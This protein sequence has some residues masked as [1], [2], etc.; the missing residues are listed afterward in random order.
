[1]NIP[2]KLVKIDAV[3]QKLMEWAFIGGLCIMWGMALHG[4]IL[5]EDKELVNECKIICL[6]ITG[7]FIMMGYCKIIDITKENLRK[8]TK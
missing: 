4:I 7:L 3:I 8:K 6:G 1:M 2:E 5:S